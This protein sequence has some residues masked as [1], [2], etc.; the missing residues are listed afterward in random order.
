[1]NSSVKRFTFNFIILILV[2]FF[3]KPIS[4]EDTPLSLFALLPFPVA[5]S[6]YLPITPVA[7]PPVISHLIK[8]S[9]KKQS[10]KN[11]MSSFY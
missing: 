7:L 11:T 3:C 8:K 10:T 6:P 4:G 5:L 9:W 2:Y 1:L